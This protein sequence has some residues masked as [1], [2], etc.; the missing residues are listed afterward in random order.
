MGV[1]T[2]PFSMVLVDPWTSDGE[3]KQHMEFLFSGQWL[4]ESNEGAP[5]SS[6]SCPAT[7]VFLRGRSLTKNLAGIIFRGLA[8]AL[9][10]C[11]I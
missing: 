3:G 11:E 7:A 9:E 5:F 6:L 1:I 4:D 10:N 2:T 8:G